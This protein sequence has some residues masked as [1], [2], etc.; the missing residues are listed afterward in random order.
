L[1]ISDGIV[2]VSMIEQELDFVLVSLAALF[3][4][5]H[6]QGHTS[7]DTTYLARDVQGSS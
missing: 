4:H 2:D 1:V 5:R 6:R 3:R 7:I